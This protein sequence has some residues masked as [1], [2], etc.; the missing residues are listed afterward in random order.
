MPM[1]LP[2]MRCSP[3]GSFEEHCDRSNPPHVV[4]RGPVNAFGVPTWKPAIGNIRLAHTFLREL[5]GKTGG[6]LLRKTCNVPRC[7]ACYAEGRPKHK[8]GTR[9]IADLTAD[10][11]KAFAER[12]LRGDRVTS[13]VWRFDLRKADA[14]K[15]AREVM[16]G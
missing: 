1:I 8:D 14:E 3:M 5:S 4:W 12:F 10:E 11:R 9:S 6:R 7:I 15:L 2:A 16:R 13:L